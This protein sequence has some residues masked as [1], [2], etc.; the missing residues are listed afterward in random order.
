MTKESIHSNKVLGLS[1]LNISSGIALLNV[2]IPNDLIL[3]YFVTSC[4]YSG[5]DENNENAHFCVF[6]YLT[7]LLPQSKAQ[8]LFHWA[9]DAQTASSEEPLPPSCAGTSGLHSSKA[10]K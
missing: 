9:A 1:K 6:K 2:F 5:M 7:A 4:I 3:N 8:T 10:P